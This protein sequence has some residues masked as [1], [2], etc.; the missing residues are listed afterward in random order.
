MTLATVAYTYDG[1]SLHNGR[2]WNL[3]LPGTNEPFARRGDNVT[4]PGISGQMYVAKD[5]EQRALRL[6]MVVTGEAK[7]GASP[8]GEVLA[9]HLDTLGALFGQAGQKTLTRRRGTRTETAQAECVN[10]EIVPRGPHH[11]DMIVDLWMA[12]PLWY[13]STVTTATTPFSSSP[14]KLAITNPGTYQNERA[15]LTITCPTFPS[16]SVTDPLFTLGSLWVKY[17]GVVAA[18]QTLT[19]DAG[20]FTATV[21]GGSVIDKITWSAAQAQ[22]MIIPRG[23]STLTLS[24]SGL[25]WTPTL[26]VTFY[27][28]YV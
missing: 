11:A 14:V 15:V 21:A 20:N 1:V 5:L 13:A 28:A 7:I 12:D 17:T 4:I 18:G 26:T 6:L 2:R 9:A 24:A 25:S 19:I 8:S 10:I 16:T 23:A 22:W 3:R 27:A